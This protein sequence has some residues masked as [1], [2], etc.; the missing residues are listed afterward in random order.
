M[1]RNSSLVLATLLVPLGLSLGA[2]SADGVDDAAPGRTPALGEAPAATRRTAVADFDRVLPWGAGD[3]AIGWRAP[4]E[5]FRGDGPSGLAVAPD[6]RVLVVDRL[7]RRL[8]AVDAGGATTLGTVAEDAE[9]L[10]AAP[11]GPI[12][13]YSPYRSR[14]WIHAEGGAPAAELAVPRG[15]GEVIRIGLDP[16]LRLEV[17][18]AFQERY[19]VGGS[20]A[21]LTPA[22]VLR[23]K[24]EGALGPSRE[25]PSGEG[26]AL[27]ALRGDDGEVTVRSV[28]ERGARREDGS[29]ARVVARLGRADAIRLIGRSAGHVVVV[30]E[31]VEQ[32][33][34]AIRVTRRL[35]VIDAATGDEAASRDLPGGLW[36]PREGVAVGGSPPAVAF[37]VPEPDGLRVARLDVADLVAAARAQGGAK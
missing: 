8:V 9:H 37:M 26:L 7:N 25:G 29:E 19:V 1:P 2:C 18:T 14:A 4:A 17:T 3:G 24:R 10:A 16:S 21:R 6:G 13:L 23:S 33:D 35:V 36:M 12:A 28:D 31:H 11:G 15:V 20:A 27:I 5:E 34:E 32:P 30:V 22:D